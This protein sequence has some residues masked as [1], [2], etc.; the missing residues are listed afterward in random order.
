MK[1]EMS[2]DRPPPS[3]QIVD[4]SGPEDKYNPLN[5]SFAKKS[6]TSLLYSLTSLGSVWASTA[7]VGMDATDCRDGR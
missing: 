2:P 3:D 6:Y 1:N 4:F 7:Y 5:W